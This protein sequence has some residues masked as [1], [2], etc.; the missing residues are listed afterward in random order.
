MAQ[1][2]KMAIEAAQLAR[3][4]GL[5]AQKQHAEASSPLTQFLEA[6]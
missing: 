2:F 6:L 1:A 4:S 5:A 3:Q